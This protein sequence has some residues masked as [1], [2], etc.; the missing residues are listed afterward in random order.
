MADNSLAVAAIQ[1]GSL[2]DVVL[3]VHPVNAAAGIIYGESVGPEQMC[4]G[5]DPPVGA[6]HVGILNARCVSPVRPVDLSAEEKVSHGKSV[7]L[8]L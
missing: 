3:G 7:S 4:I 6:V 1:I 8:T 2:N 5:N